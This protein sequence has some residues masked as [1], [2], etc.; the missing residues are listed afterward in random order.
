V[1]QEKET[2]LAQQKMAWFEQRRSL[3]E[4]DGKLIPWAEWL[5]RREN[6]WTANELPNRELHWRLRLTHTA[7]DV[8]VPRVSEKL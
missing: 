1:E 5:A 6:E 4:A 8:L 7:T 3:W 2:W